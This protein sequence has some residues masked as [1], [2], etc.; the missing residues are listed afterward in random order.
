MVSSCAYGRFNTVSNSPREA[1]P[2]DLSVRAA[3]ST[4]PAF[5]LGG[6][7]SFSSSGLFVLLFFNG[8]CS[9][10]HTQQGMI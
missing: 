7:G 4:A 1:Q 9:D 5:F 10:R 2:P 8:T 6:G 3:P